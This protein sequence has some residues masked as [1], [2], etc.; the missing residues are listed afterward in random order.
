MAPQVPETETVIRSLHQD[1]PLYYKMEPEINDEGK[2]VV[3]VSHRFTKKRKK[4][5]RIKF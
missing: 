2:L 1:R 4:N 5:G 3:T